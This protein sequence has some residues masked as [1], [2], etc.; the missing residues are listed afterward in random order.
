MKFRLLAAAA[1]VLVGLFVSWSFRTQPQ[2]SVVTLPPRGVAAAAAPLA[3]PPLPAEARPAPAAI[4]A[5]VPASTDAWRVIGSGWAAAE[6]PEF[7]AFRVWTER[8]LAAAPAERA[9]LLA[10][11]RARAAERRAVLARLI[12]SDPRAALAAAVPMVV[13]QE[14]PAEIVALLEERISG[15]GRLALNALTPAP[16]EP[17]PAETMYRSASIDGVNYRAHVYGRREM[18]ATVPSASLVGIA[19]DGQLALAESPVRVVEPGEQVAARGLAE[20]PVP[21]PAHGAQ[22]AAPAPLAVEYSGAVYAVCCAGHVTAIEA[23]LLETER[24]NEADSGPGTST[25]VGRPSQAWTH[26]TKKVLIIRVDFSDR[27]GLSVPDNG[28]AITEDFAVGL[29]NQSGGLAEFY[30]QSSFG[31]TTLQ[32]APAVAGD[33]PDVTG[34]LR[35]PATGASYAAS[36]D[37]DQLHSDARALAVAAGFDLAAYDR[38]GVVFPYIGPSTTSGRNGFAG[39]LITYGGL[40][41]VT[42]KNFWVNGFYDFRVVG[43]ELGHTYGLRHANLWVVTDGNPVSPTG[44]SLEYGDPFDLMGDGDFF[45]NDFSHWNKSL[46]QWI[47]D[48]A[49]TVAAASGTYRIYRFDA[50]GANLAQPRALKV[51]RN[52]TTDYWIGYRRA[53]TNASM[54]GGAYVLW[55]YNNANEKSNLLDLTTPGSSSNDAGLAIGATFT[56]PVAG[57]TLAPLAQGGSG[58]E[59]YLDVQ[60]TLQPRIAWTSATYLASEQGGSVV[61]TARRT[62]NATGAIS[63]NF[64]T[65][66]G[67]ATSPADYTAQS[68]TLTWANGDMADKT[69]TLTLAPDALVEGVET[70]TVTLSGIT[71]GVLGDLSVATVSIADPG[72]RDATFTADFINSTVTSVLSLPDGSA[73]IAGWFSSV[74]NDAF[75]SFSRGGITRITANGDVDPDFASAGG[76]NSL[77]LRGL[78]RQPD[79]KILVL[80]PFSTFN[81]AAHNRL[82]RLNADG[83]TDSTFAIGTGA[84]AAINAMLVQPDGKIILGGNFNT[85][86]GVARETLVRLNADGSVDTTWVGPD[87]AGNAADAAAWGWVDAL[88]LQADGKLLVGGAFY[89]NGG[90]L[91]GGLCRLNANGALDT[92]F[93]GISDGFKSGQFIA[94]PDEI[95][96]QPDGKILLAGNFTHYNG[97]ARAGLARLTNTGELDATFAPVSNG[98]VNAL[99]YLPDGRVLLGGAFT[100]INGTA[101]SRIALLSASGAVDTAFAAAGGHGSTVEDLAL[102]A[103]GRVWLAGNYAAFQGY[104]GSSNGSPLWRFFSGLNGTPGEVQLASPTYAGTEGN[105]VQLSVTRTGSGIGALSVGYA[106]VAGSAGAADFTGASGVLTWA[107]GDTAAKTIS[108]PLAT[109]ASAEGVESF[110]VNLGQPLLGGVVLG[111]NQQAVVDIN[112]PAL[113]GYTAFR[114]AQFTVSEQANNAI[115]GPAADPD[116]DGLNNLLEYALGL[117]P[118]SA[119]ASAALPVVTTTATDW[120]FTYTRPVN[121]SDLVYAVHA[122]TNLTTWGPTNVTHSFVSSD[123][124]RETW[125]GTYPLA[126]G[127]NVFFRLHVTLP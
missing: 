47:P 30:T 109:D 56:D 92:T 28:P 115:S 88:A 12:K 9:A 84:N 80:G 60:V 103:D 55:G 111:A 97:T 36:G 95:T 50:S 59:E 24:V 53:T 66:N 26:G 124:T 64:A 63:V 58:A 86:N 96:V 11:G 93:T 25:V 77:P 62:A 27:P 121:R 85:F 100:D 6:Q 65:A 89:F 127:S 29:I 68:G 113:T 38:I 15:Q 79:G 5:A 54:D 122:S 123:G 116:G 117:A 76:A 17:V 1:F 8:Y 67:T 114:S 41:N 16:G 33:S 2:G 90:P 35:M 87:F 45:A 99:I 83:S 13:R 119:D 19:L 49:V 46:L 106:T 105:T 107:A 61:L 74:Q 23:S 126:L 69:V 43:H 75:Q 51:V 32:I 102:T 22:E 110:T 71:G 48:T 34:L 44:T 94:G 42:G 52:S 14:L 39:S 125:R 81:G 18:Q 104:G 21:V 112:D 108:V 91:K 37:D 40:A 3:L 57:I 98:A 82:V 72:V 31:K 78:A 20:S 120:V 101:L 10:E 118:K 73:I 4:A 7:A 70:F